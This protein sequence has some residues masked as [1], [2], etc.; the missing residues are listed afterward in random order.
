MNKILMISPIKCTD[1]GTCESVCSNDAVNVITLEADE[2]DFSVPIMCMQCEDAACLEICPTGALSRN[3]SDVVVIDENKCVGCK[4]CVGACPFG[5]IQYNSRK[6]R[7]MKCD[8]C[9]GSPDCVKYCPKQ[10]IEFVV[11]TESNLKKKR[12]V[13][14]KFKAL[15]E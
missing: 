12:L 4:M 5:N 13:A 2:E 3:S 7:I 6:K 14:S 15:F 8:L 9:G 11:G 1:C 10:A